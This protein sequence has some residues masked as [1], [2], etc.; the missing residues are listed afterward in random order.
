MCDHVCLVLFVCFRVSLCAFVA[1]G[2]LDG[3]VFVCVLA[4]VCLGL[5]VRCL[6]C[7]FLF[8]CIRV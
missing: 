2:C 1:C 8:G 3:F 7:D 6:F 4:W 5:F